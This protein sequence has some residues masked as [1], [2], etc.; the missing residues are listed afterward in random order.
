MPMA[1]TGPFHRA[2]LVDLV[3]AGGGLSVV[4][5]EPAIEVA[6]SYASP[7]QYVEVRA[8]GETGY[9]VLANEHGASRFDLVMRAGGGAS[10]VLLA[11]RPGAPI[12]VSRAIGPGFPLDEVKARPLVIALT[13]TGIAA[14]RPLVRPRIAGGDAERT[15]LLVGARKHS[16]LAMHADLDLWER[17]GVHVLVCLSQPEVLAGALEADVTP[18]D[19]RIVRGYVQDVFR[20]RA[21]F[22][23]EGA[24][25]FAVGRSSMVDALRDTAPTL[26]IARE[27]VYTNH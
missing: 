8:N 7:G 5:V 12:E 6:E 15:L 22:P 9:F 20:N 27:H 19:R 24:R 18:R 14:G 17:A 2:R 4:T 3:D 25:V 26:G 1:E 23:L 10:D 13:G 21:G 11:M 16:E